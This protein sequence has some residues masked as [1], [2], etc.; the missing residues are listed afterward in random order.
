MLRLAMTLFFLLGAALAS[1]ANVTVVGVMGKRV[2]FQIDGAQRLVGEGERVTGS[3]RVTEISNDHVILESQGRKQ[4]VGIGQRVLAASGGDETSVLYANAQGHY[5]SSGSIN[6]QP[7]R[8]LVDT[9]A[10]TIAMGISDARKLGLN[11]LQG[12]TM[13]AAT[14][15]GSMSVTCVQVE[16]VSLGDI[17]MTNV[18]AC[19]SEKEMP[20][21]LLGMSFLSRTEMKNVGS[22]LHLKKKY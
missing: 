8:F 7:V 13:G 21:I 5:I 14:A 11:K 1:A 3:F 10:T 12:N 9:G 19:Y 17:N 6:D 2:M 16:K 4:R 18:P 15:N 22:Q 20:I